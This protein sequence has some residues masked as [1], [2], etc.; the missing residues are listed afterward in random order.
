MLSKI[1]AQAKII[2]IIT[3]IYP[4]LSLA[5]PLQTGFFSK[6]KFQPIAIEQELVAVTTTNPA[7]ISGT[8]PF[9]AKAITRFA[10]VGVELMP[11]TAVTRAHSIVGYPFWFN[12]KTGAV[13]ILTKEIVVRS[14]DFNA[15]EIVLATSGIVTVKKLPFRRGLLLASYTSPLKALSAANKLF[16]IKGIRYAHPNFMIPKDFRQLRPVLTPNNEPYYRHQ[17][18]LSNT[19]QTGGIKG[20]DIRAEQAWSIS[21]GAP[22]VRVA[23]IDGGFEIGQEDLANAWYVNKSETPADGI[24]NDQNGYIDDTIGWN[25][26]ADSPDHSKSLYP[27]HGTAV[28]GLLGARVNGLGTT[29]VCPGCTLIPI[30]TSFDPVA[31]A[32]AIYYAEKAKADV[33]TNSWGYP[34]GTPNT[35]V[36]TEAIQ[37]VARSGRDGRGTIVLF[38]MNNIDNDDC[39]GDNPDISSMPEVI[40]ISAS[41]DQDKKYIDS[42]WGSCMDFIA[43]TWMQQ[44][45]FGGMVTAD[46]S[47]GD[48]YN[49]KR[50]KDDFS[51][52]NY[53]R[54]F[55]GTS[56]ATPVAAGIFGLMLA[57]DA[58]LTRDQAFEIMRASADKVASTEAR[59]DPT[60]GHSN[61]YGFGRVDAAQATLAT[62]LR[63]RRIGLMNRQ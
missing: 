49:P 58:S 32:E 59:Y 35:D 54:W 62:T 43:P 37:F 9:P 47:G 16:K 51:D 38:A 56:A 60:T 24:D 15:P 2:L 41:T 50:T 5:A 8:T 17:W 6:G 4:P 30:T 52:Q 7:T 18:H 29:G 13:G 10:E 61:L 44:H 63:K 34:I 27:N 53:T 45:K 25:F 12:Q 57:I 19:G 26:R 46:L 23:I 14:D 55:N 22:T 40:A 21:E 33:I 20:A 36:V 48:G 3:V 31:D 28:A 1:S 42:G 11:R 39:S